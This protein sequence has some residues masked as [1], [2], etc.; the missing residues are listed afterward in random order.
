MWSQKKEALMKIVS[1]CTVVLIAGF[2]SS[3]HVIATS[4]TVTNTIR[5]ETSVDVTVKI[6]FAL[7][8]PSI[9]FDLGTG[10]T[11]TFDSDARCPE[12]AVVT[13]KGDQNSILA[14]WSTFFCEYRPDRP[15]TFRFIG[16]EKEYSLLVE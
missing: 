7:S 15:F 4:Y 14:S 10:K 13:A 2:I 1:L 3:A 9:E 16:K 8:A 11:H 12:G 6:S 5:N